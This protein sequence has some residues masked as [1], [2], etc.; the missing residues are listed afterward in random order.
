MMCTGLP[1]WGVMLSFSAFVLMAL[2]FVGLRQGAQPRQA[3]AQQEARRLQSW[4]P[5]DPDNKAIGA[6]A[7]ETGECMVTI[8]EHRTWNGWSAT[9][10]EGSYDAWAFQRKGGKL[11]EA[12]T[13]EMRGPCQ[14]ILFEN[15]DFTGRHLIIDNVYGNYDL[16]WF[17]FGDRASSLL[18]AR[19]IRTAWEANNC[20]NKRTSFRDQGFLAIPNKTA[21][22][23]TAAVAAASVD[24]VGIEKQALSESE[25]AVESAGCK[26][27]LY[28]E[29]DQQGSR[30]V[31]DGAG[32]R[33]N[34]YNPREELH[35]M[36]MRG[37]QD[38]S[39]VFF[40]RNG[41]KEEFM[42]IHGNANKN[43]DYKAHSFIFGRGLYPVWNQN[44]Y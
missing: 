37:P 12:S 13:M 5:S 11:K 10:G 30:I 6:V 18:V 23:E 41:F 38:C 20:G 28:S 44:C 25:V 27:V 3:A 35:S 15:G 7:A 17:G 31:F 22:D 24:G 14:V 1:G 42:A 29:S 34:Q 32:S 2:G 39:V 43:F 8:Y 9:F 16:G 19:D 4:S 21:S 33:Y 26:L 40:R 36:S